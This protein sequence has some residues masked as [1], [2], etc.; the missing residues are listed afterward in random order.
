VRA[1]RQRLQEQFGVFEGIA[2]IGFK[3]VHGTHK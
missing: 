1:V 3:I 2:Q